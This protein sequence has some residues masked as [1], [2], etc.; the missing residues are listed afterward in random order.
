MSRLENELE[1][2][3]ASDM[4][5]VVFMVDPKHPDYGMG[6]YDGL[7]VPIH[8][9][10]GW[11]NLSKIALQF[12]KE[13]KAEYEEALEKCKSASA[14]AKLKVPAKKELFHWKATVAAKESMNATM[15]EQKLEFV[16]D[17]RKNLPPHLSGSYAHP[18]VC[19]DF[20]QW[21]SRKDEESNE[22]VFG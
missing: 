13:Q 21:M 9:S 4:S 2:Q 12:N 3:T 16:L 17:E 8:R 18:D 7:T 5:K 11:P 19:L 22:L 10:S 14:K 1:Y 20:V 15:T 6:I